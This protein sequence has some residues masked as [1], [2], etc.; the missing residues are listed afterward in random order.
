M[1]NVACYCRVSTEEQAKYGFSIEAQRNAL[2]K[3]CK[4][5]GYKYTFYIDEGISASSMKKRDA[6]NSMLEKIK[7]YDMVL[8]TKLDRLSRNVLDANNINKLLIENHCTMKA[9]DEDD[10]DTSTADGMFLFNLKVSLAQREIGKTSER[11]KFVFA[12]KREKGEA[13]S[14]TKKY[15]YD[16]V[17][18]HYVVNEEESLNIKN[19]YEEC[20][21]NNGNLSDT[22]AYF[23]KHFPGKGHD[24]MMGYLRDTSYI[25]K[26]KLYRKDIYLDNYIP[27]IID[28]SL[29]DKVQSLLKKRI[30]KIE[31]SP[32]D[33]FSG[34]LYCG[35]CNRRI[36]KKVDYRTK[37]ATIRYICDYSYRY[38]IGSTD[39]KCN[40]NKSIREDLIEQYLFE[41]LDSAAKKYITKC[42]IKPKAKITENASKAAAIEKKLEKLKDLY[43]DDL[44][45][46]DTYKKDYSRLTMELKA[47]KE[48]SK[49]QY[50]KKDL[51]YLK[52]ILD[53]D[54]KEIYKT[55]TIQNKKKFWL[56]IIDKIIIEDGN[57][58][59]VIFL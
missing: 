55:L 2:E 9:I 30:R 18:K 13:T 56:S 3:Y 10:V 35:S 51:S 20:V 23:V 25:G 15:G 36:S 12:N 50:V 42:S 44:I 31:K 6:L 14:G 5:N 43:I 34:L 21:K 40:N 16:I 46:K 11:I 26:Y 54:Y 45:N 8:F 41:N 37:A 39:K 29:W 47:L 27:P 28:R 33:L 52:K 7:S 49:D 22:Y 24:A 4:M 48:K 38:N 32:N 53:S 17:N 58:K 59:E 19:L 1:K 57:I